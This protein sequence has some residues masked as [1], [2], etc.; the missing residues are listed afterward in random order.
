MQAFAKNN[1]TSIELP[2]SLKYMGNIAF[3]DNKLASVKIPK[4]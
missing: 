1:L 4:T 2:E 3:M